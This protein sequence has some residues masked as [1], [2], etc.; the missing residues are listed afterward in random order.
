M[1]GYAGCK[2]WV[3]FV[4]EY[5]VGVTSPAMPD[6]KFQAQVNAIHEAVNA[7]AGAR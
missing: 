2:S 6:R 7:A 3:Q 4:E 5:P 1:E